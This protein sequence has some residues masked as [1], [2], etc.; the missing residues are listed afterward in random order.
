MTVYDVYA[1]P[2]GDMESR[3][4]R[5]GPGTPTYADAREG[6]GNAVVTA[7]VSGVTE[8]TI[9]QERN[10]AYLGGPGYFTCLE[11]FLRFDLS[12]FVSIASASLALRTGSDQST[13]DFVM[14]ARSRAWTTPLDAADYVAG[15]ALG[16]DTLV[17][18]YDTASGLTGGTYFT[19][20]DVA[21]LAACPPGGQAQFV[22]SSSRHRLNVAPTDLVPEYVFITTGASGPPKLTVDGVKGRPW[23]IGAVAIG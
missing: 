10:S 21:L 18:T 20:V 7:A 23:I 13:T 19:M 3:S 15:S 11:L 1:T 22:V 9:G 17:A 14:E 16:S 2:P 4:G 8:A 6:T 12:E 5:P